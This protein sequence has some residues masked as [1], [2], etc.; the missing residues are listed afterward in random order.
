MEDILWHFST[1]SSLQDA[2]Q[3]ALVQ[4]SIYLVKEDQGV[5]GSSTPQSQ[6]RGS[7]FQTHQLITFLYTNLELS[8]LCSEVSKPRYTSRVSVRFCKYAKE[9]PCKVS[10]E[11]VLMRHKLQLLRLSRQFVPGCSLRD[12]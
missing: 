10:R 2:S 11:Q 6:R 9:R 3:Q 12:E 7:Y 1:I 8:L 5:I 4:N